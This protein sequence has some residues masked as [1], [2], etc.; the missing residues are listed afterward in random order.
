MNQRK[1][2]FQILSV[3]AAFS[4]NA[5]TDT[6]STSTSTEAAAPKLK[7]TAEPAKDFSAKSWKRN[8]DQSAS[9]LKAKRWQEVIGLLNSSLSEARIDLGRSV[10]LG[11]YLSRLGQ[12]YFFSNNDDAS[13]PTF[14]E[15]LKLYTEAAPSDKPPKEYIY[16]DYSYLGRSY[17]NKKMYD[18][19]Q[20]NL[21]KALEYSK[22]VPASQIDK[23][24]LKEIYL[25]AE[26]SYLSQHKMREAVDVRNERYKLFGKGK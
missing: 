9:L 15:A 20:I 14:V 13:I 3:L 12:A 17:L 25:C 23:S 7:P 11:R 24:W 6:H 5:C 19:A 1:N 21:V 18:K 26:S 16:A 4:L 2:L 22:E 8:F 10:M